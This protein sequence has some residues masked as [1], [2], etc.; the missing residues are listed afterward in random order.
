[1]LLILGFMETHPTSCRDL[2]IVYITLV[3]PNVKI[4]Q[5]VAEFLQGVYFNVLYLIV[6][7]VEEFI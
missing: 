7:S 3:L 1:M 5:A 4:M 6:T 2:E